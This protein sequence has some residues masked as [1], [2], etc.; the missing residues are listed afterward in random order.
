MSHAPFCQCGG[1]GNLSAGALAKA[2]ARQLFGEQ[3]PRSL[4]VPNEALAA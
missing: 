3:L 1:L 2:E 4:D